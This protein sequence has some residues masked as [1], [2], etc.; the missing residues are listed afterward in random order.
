MTTHAPT[1]SFLKSAAEYLDLECPTTS[2][3]D[4]AEAFL[5]AEFLEALGDGPDTMVSC[6][7]VNGI[8]QVPV[9]KVVRAMFYAEGSLSVRLCEELA[10]EEPDVPGLLARR[11]AAAWLAY[12]DAAEALVAHAAKESQS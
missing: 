10:S 9:A 2:N 6:P 5:V 12:L 7:P 8:E 1:E 4:E 3:R 11:F